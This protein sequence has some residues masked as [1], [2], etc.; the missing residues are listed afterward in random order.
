MK[1]VLFFLYLNFACALKFISKGLDWVDFQH[2]K[3][4]AGGAPPAVSSGRHVHRIALTVTTVCCVS[5]PDKYVWHRVLLLMAEILHQL[6]GSLS[7]DFQFFIHPRWC[8]ISSI[9]STIVIFVYHTLVWFFSASRFKG[10]HIMTVFFNFGYSSNNSSMVKAENS[11]I[12]SYN[13]WFFGDS[14][15]MQTY[16]QTLDWTWSSPEEFIHAAV[17]GDCLQLCDPR[18][19]TAPLST[20]VL[21]GD[22]IQSLKFNP[23]KPWHWEKPCIGRCCVSFCE[24]SHWFRDQHDKVRS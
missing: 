17:C 5:N 13:S 8:R 18:T 6:I 20:T 2:V 12:Q 23:P 22:G 14:R 24:G 16:L 1:H 19:T 3:P 7:H 15:E 4:I 11:Y 10:L 21:P 9:N